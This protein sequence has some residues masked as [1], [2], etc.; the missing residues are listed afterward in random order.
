MSAGEAHNLD[1]GRR[2]EETS[3]TSA[4]GSS[5]PGASAAPGVVNCVLWHHSSKALPPELLSSLCKRGVRITVCTDPYRTMAHAVRLGSRRQAMESASLVL[6]LVQPSGLPLASDV[7]LAVSKYA[8]HA[9]CWVYEPTAGAKGGVAALRAATPADLRAWRE[10]ASNESGAARGSEPSAASV[11]AR[12][13]TL[14]TDAH[15]TNGEAAPASSGVSDS[16][17]PVG[18]DVIGTVGKPGTAGR[19]N[20]PLSVGRPASRPTGPSLRL[21][22]DDGSEDQSASGAPAP[23]RRMSAALTEEELSMLLSDDPWE[24]GGETGKEGNAR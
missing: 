3:S 9:S 19:T 1:G 2:D 23:A 7:V 17:Q 20:V 11:H 21:T 16:S 13:T 5:A 12:A 4:C 15:Q 22:Q 10:A 24:R 8:P 6:L 18:S 14:E